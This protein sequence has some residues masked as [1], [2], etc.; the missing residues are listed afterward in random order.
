MSENHQ[1]H[2]HSDAAV[3]VYRVVL[4]SEL[5]GPD[6]G[7]PYAVAYPAGPTLAWQAAT[8]D[9]ASA[10]GSAFGWDYVA[11]V[12]GRAQTTSPLIMSVIPPITKIN[13]TPKEN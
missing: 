4:P 7:E 6:R 3:S 8:E 1:D 9:R 12:W 13:T 11:S 2:P 10:Y 5:T